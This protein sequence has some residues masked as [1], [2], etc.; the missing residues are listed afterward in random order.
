MEKSFTSLSIRSNLITRIKLSFIS[1]IS[2]EIES[3]PRLAGRWSS[4]D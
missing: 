3:A 2:T 4:N 1:N